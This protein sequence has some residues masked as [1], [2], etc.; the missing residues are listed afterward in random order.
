MAG[1]SGGGN[2][3]AVMNDTPMGMRQI[4]VVFLMVLLRKK[5]P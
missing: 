4:L 2:P 1:P 5:Y 3:V